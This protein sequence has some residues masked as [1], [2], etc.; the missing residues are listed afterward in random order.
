M[1]SDGGVYAIMASMH[2]CLLLW[3]GFLSVLVATASCGHL[4]SESAT[5]YPRPRQAT[6]VWI[7]VDGLRHDYIER[8]HPPVLSKLAREGAY[9]N[10]EMPIFPSLTFPNHTAQVTGLRV[11]GSGIPTNVFFDQETGKG[12]NLP[13]QADLFR[14]DPIWVT[15]KRQGVRSAVIGWPMSHNQP[16]PV[17]ADY[18]DLSYDKKETDAQRLDRIVT[19]LNNDDDKKPIRLVM[20][21]VFKLDSAG[22]VFGP[23]AP[24]V[25]KTL[26]QVDAEIGKFIEGVTRWFDRTHSPTDELY[27][28][29]STDHGMQKIDTQVSLDL[30]LGGELIKD[31]KF[32]PSGPIATIHL[33]TGLSADQ[34]PARVAAIVSK[35]Q[36]NAFLSVWPA[37][38]VPAKYH[39]AD[40][41]R[42]GDVVV[43]LHPGYAFTPLRLSATQPAV[44]LKGNHG[45]DPAICSNMLGSAIIW[46]YRHPIGGVDLGRIDNTQWYPTVTRLLDITPSPGADERPIAIRR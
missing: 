30:L 15:A 13:D 22:H 41:S 2:S 3:I 45:Y 25:D 12:Y 43:L 16:G 6:V 8:V 35:L 38:Q 4:D 7:S 9:T 23:D 18:F 26:L 42:V 19:L 11:D 44:Q 21:Y 5:V 31:L 46:Q 27:V 14:V 28:I 34:R 39:F 10:Q 29:I 33:P 36:N 1:L 20:T 40:R 24:E 17:K 37:N 32:A